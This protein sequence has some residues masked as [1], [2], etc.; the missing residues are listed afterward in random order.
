MV[1]FEWDAAK[2]ERNVA[3]HGIDFEDATGIFASAIVVHRS[4]RAGEIR[5]AAIGEVEG[6]E[7]AVVYTIR[8][9]RYRIISV[10]RA[11][12]NER[13]AYRK[14]RPGG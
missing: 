7:V 13:E 11:R 9:E 6:R 5:F 12:E 1:E 10:R 2:N 4:D 3:L 14:A 8:G